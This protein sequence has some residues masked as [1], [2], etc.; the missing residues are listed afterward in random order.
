MAAEDA[1]QAFDIARAAAG[2]P[3]AMPGSTF[4]LR[5]RHTSGETWEPAVVESRTVTG[6]AA[7]TPSKAVTIR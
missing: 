3:E 6:R 5:S 1:E 4:E 2:S 7:L